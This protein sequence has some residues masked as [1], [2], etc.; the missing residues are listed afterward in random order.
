MAKFIN[1][2]YSIYGCIKKR[3]GATVAR[4][5][6]FKK[7]AATLVGTRNKVPV[8]YGYEELYFCVQCCILNV[9]RSGFYDWRNSS[10]GQCKKDNNWLLD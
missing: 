6:Y 8:Y 2:I 7:A 5:R 4:T 10:E 3:S 1:V 9:S